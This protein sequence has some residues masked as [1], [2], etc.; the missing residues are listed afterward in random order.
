MSDK[1]LGGR[2]EHVPSQKDRLAVEG[3]A[4][5]GAPQA[6]IAVVIGIDEKTLR[7]HYREELDTAAIKANAKVA[8][9]HYEKCIGRPAVSH[10][11]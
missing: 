4:R 11:S 10:R 9:S 1:N 7:K 2:P 6:H 5:Y 8:Q 3:M